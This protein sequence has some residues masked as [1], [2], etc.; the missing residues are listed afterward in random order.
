MVKSSALVMAVVMLAV[1]VG[2]YFGLSL[3]PPGLIPGIGAPAGHSA[4]PS[5]AAD[6]TP[7]Q[8]ADPAPVAAAETDAIEPAEDV[9]TPQAESQTEATPEAEPTTIAARGT[10]AA[11]YG[12]SEEIERALANEPPPE[13]GAVD[14]GVRPVKPAPA[15]SEPVKPAAEP[16]DKPAAAK[17]AEASPSPAPTA[18]TAS[19]K[20]PEA[21]AAPAPQP[22]P[23]KKPEAAP[24]PQPKAAAA[25]EPKPAPAATAEAST[26]PAAPTAGTTA[27]AD[28]LKQWWPDPSSMPTNQ[29]KLVYAGQVRGQNSIALLFS[30]ALNLDS[31]KANVQVK[32]NDGSLAAGDWTIGKNP[33]LAIINGLAPGRYTVVLKPAI[34]GQS[35]FMLGTT[36]QGPV[37]IQAP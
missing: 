3:V 21:A 31:L 13:G 34:A 27:G 36:L 26:A 9:E 6:P 11:D 24:A 28:A 5:P 35:G 12:S 16:A 20:D 1:A 32:A 19:A 10:G 14:G 18:S 23:A 15:P 17:S 7:S 2:T 8:T 33:K 29:L 22:K 4:A 30:D 25:P 37:Y